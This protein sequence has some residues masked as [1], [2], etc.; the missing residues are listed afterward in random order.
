VAN[1]QASDKKSN[2]YYRIMRLHIIITI[3][4]A[5]ASAIMSLCRVLIFLA[6]LAKPPN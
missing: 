5:V 2:K 6:K 4:L 1:E 3:S